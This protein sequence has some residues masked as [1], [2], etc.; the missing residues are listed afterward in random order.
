MDYAV[1][2]LPAA[3][4][5]RKPNHR[6][7]MVSQLLF[8]ETVIVLKEKGDLW[9]KV[10][11]LHDGYEGWTTNTLIQEVDEAFAKSKSNYVAD[12]LLNQLIVGDKKINIP[13]G[14]SLPEMV[15][16]TIAS[17]SGTFIRTDQQTPGETLIRK[18]TTPW[19]NA[20]YLWGGRTILGVDCSGFVQV[21]YKMMGIDLP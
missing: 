2:A 13:P 1:V 12:G 5:R 10:R 4:L 7:E 15:A 8:G 17:H 21:I 9:V 6:S 20:P 18:L 3:P 11:G 19:L 16:E 14:A